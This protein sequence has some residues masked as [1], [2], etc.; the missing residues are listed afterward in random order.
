MLTIYVLRGHR[1]A[2]SDYATGLLRAYV[3]KAK[4]QRACRDTSARYKALNEKAEREWRA[5]TAFLMT[6]ASELGV[7]HWKLPDEIIAQAPPYPKW[8][9]WDEITV[10]EVA[11]MDPD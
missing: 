11:L 9:K 6:R 7:K 10:D 5:Y 1:G 3:D 8:P 2:Y 4:A